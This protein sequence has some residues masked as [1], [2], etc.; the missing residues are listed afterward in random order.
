MTDTRLRHAVAGRTIL[1]TGTSCAVTDAAARHLSRAGAR[2]LVA[3]HPAHRS[4]GEVWVYRADPAAPATMRVLAEQ[5]LDEHD[6]L[7]IVIHT[8]GT[9]P[10]QPSARNS[11]HPINTH[12]VGPTTLIRGL[13][14][15]LRDDGSA[16]LINVSPA[17]LRLPLP[18]RWGG[19]RASK[20]AFD[21]WFRGLARKARGRG[22]TTTSVYTGLVGTDVV[23]LICDAIT[24][25]PRQI[26]PWWLKSG[27]AIGH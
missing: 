2:V 23:T 12:Y 5:L 11:R 24:L 25:R 21:T 7:D 13:L 22:V 17:H 3:T 8:A 14:P 10:K 15:A 6:R 9:P 16:Q 1:L 26:A 19:H 4:T 20:A 18:A 27:R